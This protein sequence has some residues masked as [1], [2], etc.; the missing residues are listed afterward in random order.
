[1]TDIYPDTG[2]RWIRTQD[3][4]IVRDDGEA[5]PTEAD[6]S[7]AAADAAASDDDADTSLVMADG[8]AE[9]DSAQDTQE[10]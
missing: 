8:D 4:G 9:T 6:P 5:A 7:N 1:M 10:S 3:G 2:G